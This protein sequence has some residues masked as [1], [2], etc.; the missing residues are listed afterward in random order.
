MSFDQN[1]Q[2]LFTGLGQ[3]SSGF[4][5]PA[6]STSAYRSFTRNQDI[7]RDCADANGTII[8][9]G[10][11][12]WIARSTDTGSTWVEQIPDN[13][14][15]FWTTVATNGSGYWVAY[16]YHLYG[17]GTYMAWSTDDGIN[18]GVRIKTTG[19][20]VYKCIYAAGRFHFCSGGGIVCSSTDGNGA[21]LQETSTSDTW[22][23]MAYDSST[24]LIV[25]SGYRDI[26]AFPNQSFT[27][28]FWASSGYTGS[29]VNYWDNGT[30]QGE[31]VV[32]IRYAPSINKLVSINDVIPY[33]ST[34][35]S[36]ISTNALTPGI[37]SQSV[38]LQSINNM[39][40]PKITDLAWGSDYG[41]FIATGL[42]V[43][44]SMAGAPI[45]VYESTDGINWNEGTLPAGI[46]FGD[47]FGGI[48]YS[49][50]YN[51]FM[52]FGGGPA[53]K[54]FYWYS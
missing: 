47:T 34:I 50:Y 44:I 5:A 12:G 4:S 13:D 16:G 26:A 15:I 28:T 8:C 10:D 9:V 24:N 52:V 54:F 45:S 32:A 39:G 53:G 48:K 18:W 3:S 1:Q 33:Q 42:D 51:K 20:I 6:S 35:T 37:R 41:K 43:R 14:L 29:L 40:F 17:W 22:F 21:I 19:G 25:L 49:D 30:T 23:D 11:W 7:I 31:G 38:A 27:G 46:G 2:N 36:S